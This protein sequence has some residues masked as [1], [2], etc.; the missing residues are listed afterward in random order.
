MSPKFLSVAGPNGRGHVQLQWHIAPDPRA[1]GGINLLPLHDEDVPSF[2]TVYRGQIAYGKWQVPVAIKVQRDTTG[3]R[4]SLDSIIARFSSERLI[5]QVLAK[6]GAAGAAARGGLPIVSLHEIGDESADEA[7][8]I[9][10]SILCRRAAHALTPLCPKCARPLV[11]SDDQFDP[12]NPQEDDVRRLR[13]PPCKLAW[14]ATPE[15]KRVIREA[16]V[17]RQHAC[18][19]CQYFN[20]AG[21]VCHLESTFLNFF[22]ARV[23]VFELLD[24]SLAD[25][26]RYRENPA[27]PSGRP[28]VVAAMADYDRSQKTLA[29]RRRV[30]A[31]LARLRLTCELLRDVLDG[32]NLLHANNKAHLDLKPDDVCL[33]LDQDRIRA[34]LIDLGLASD[35]A[36]PAKFRAV[37]EVHALRTD[38]A[39][40]ELERPTETFRY[41][42]GNQSS[43]NEFLLKLARRGDGLDPTDAQAIKGDTVVLRPDSGG[44]IPGEVVDVREGHVLVRARR[45]E[46]SL[47]MPFHGKGQVVV[48]KQAGP[49]ADY[50]SFG[51]LVF[52][53]VLGRVELR[54]VRALLPNL[55]TALRELADARPG[56]SRTPGRWAVRRLVDRDSN[57][58]RGFYQIV[59]QLT[60]AYSKAEYLA[61]EL[62]GLALRCVVRGV[63]GWS[64][65]D[66]RGDWSDQTRRETH[67]RLDRIR[68]AVENAVLFESSAS[69]QEVRASRLR[70][71]RK[72]VQAV[73]ADASPAGRPRKTSPR[74][75]AWLLETLS[76]LST[77]QGRDENEEL[78][79]VMNYSGRAAD[80]IRHL[81]LLEHELRSAGGEANGSETLLVNLIDWWQ[82]LASTDLTAESRAWP[83]S[84]Q[85]LADSNMRH[86]S[87][88]DQLRM[89]LNKLHL[90][91]Y[92]K[93]EFSDPPLNAVQH[94]PVDREAHRTVNLAGGRDAIRVLQELSESSGDLLSEIRAQSEQAL[95]DW[96]AGA[97]NTLLARLTGIEAF[98]RT[99]LANVIEEHDKWR[100]AYLSSLTLVVSFLD[101]ADGLKG[102]W[103][104]WVKQA[105]QPPG[106]LSRLFLIQPAPTINLKFRPREVNRDGFKRAR[107]AIER[108]ASISL[109]P[110]FQLF[111]QYAFVQG[112]R[113]EHYLKLENKQTV[114]SATSCLSCGQ[115]EQAL[116]G[117]LDFLLG[118]TGA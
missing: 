46:L 111:C 71:W 92:E 109:G 12:E 76:L 11:S 9:A 112:E 54:D 70:E 84:W 20:A 23:L 58:L 67:C 115:V 80:L 51:L 38:Y 32:L 89:M 18:R 94:V 25:Y 108:L 81:H 43:P 99:G 42:D 2:A 75:S 60:D 49:P 53:L 91:L 41:Y 68:E 101:D 13:C 63:P 66:H 88:V 116:G 24:L 83:D 82:A 21:P 48:Y 97:T 7:P 65:C 87:A 30:P 16:S 96:A 105:E 72:S 90:L 39:A 62:L 10:P 77:S 14:E 47:S 27:H 69:L 35:P 22:P 57:Y 40:P 15:N 29:E 6:A 36:T 74:E 64:L 52:A 61:E 107:K 59:R 78:Q 26:L 117:G 56:I 118:H 37:M 19:A 34:R 33:R 8:Q 106:F 17:A 31:P 3:A 45:G 104:E 28:D 110:A 103:T 100:T 50:Y 98:V 79:T 44:N 114:L 95:A 86:T 1:D 5:H 55:A 85:H 4:D 102:F 73:G 113:T 93:M